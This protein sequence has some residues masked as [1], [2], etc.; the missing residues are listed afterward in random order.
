MKIETVKDAKNY[1][2]AGNS[3]FTLKS[4]R[5]GK[6]FTFKF[7]KRQSSSYLFYVMVLSGSTYEYIGSIVNGIFRVTPTVKNDL[8][9][10]THLEQE[11]I[12][13]FL[14]QLSSKKE[15]NENLEIWHDGKCGRCRRTLTHPDSISS[16]LGPECVKYVCK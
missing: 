5:T 2:F 4:L 6:H 11:T 3:I 10:K 15:L 9:T 12:K 7:K 14:R 16:G 1:V 13:W 8:R